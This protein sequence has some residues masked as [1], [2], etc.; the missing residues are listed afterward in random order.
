MKLNVPL[1]PFKEPSKDSM[2]QYAPRPDAGSNAAVNKVAERP[3]I[4]PKYCFSI[5]ATPVGNPVWISGVGESTPGLKFLVLNV[6][7]IFHCCV[8]LK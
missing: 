3:S 7:L 8:L 1:F 5:V 4:C 6:P 2:A